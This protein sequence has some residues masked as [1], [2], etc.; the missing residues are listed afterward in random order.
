M[1]H[2]IIIVDGLNYFTRHF[3]ANPTMSRQ[4]HQIGGFVGFLKG[5]KILNDRLS[6]RRV[7]VIWEGGGSPR[8]RA[9]F[10]EYKSGRRPQRL[11]RYYEDI[12]DTYENRDYQ[13]KLTIES[14]RHAPV[15]Q[16]Y[17][18]DCEADDVI[19]YMCR[20]MFRNNKIVVVSSDKDLYQL[21]DNNVAQWSPG[22]KKL[23]TPEEVREKFGVW[24]TNM[25][26]VRSFV[27]D[28]SDGI[29]G[30]DGA[31]FKTMSKRFPLLQEDQS[32]MLQDILDEASRHSATK[33]QLYKNIVDK[34]DIVRRNWK[35][36][37]LDIANLSGDQIKKINDSV[38][39]YSPKKNKLEMMR[40]L[41]REGVQDFD[42]DSFFMTLNA[43]IV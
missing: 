16:I 35:L 36:M 23:I 19:G 34:Q 5:L 22:Q 25:C 18:S 6:S 17:V 14:L 12:P 31:G 38:S 40:L 10:P 39:S 28:S 15:Q 11:N 30:V 8:R 29:P 33:V 13:L 2:P 9:I 27:G 42:V 21:I 24:P 7:I 37:H 32:L 3:V 26:L 20:H 43:T 41:I 1:S 4:G